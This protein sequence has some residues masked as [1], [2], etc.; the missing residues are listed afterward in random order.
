MHDERSRPI[1]AGR[2]FPQIEVDAPRYDL[3]SWNVAL[4]F[5]VGYQH[6]IA[7]GGSQL[8]VPDLYG[9]GKVRNQIIGILIDIIERRELF[10]SAVNSDL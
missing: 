4:Q 9:F 3:C 2:R 7:D 10:E 8:N 6:M 1:C 5:R